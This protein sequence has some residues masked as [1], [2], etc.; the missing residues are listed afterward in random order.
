MLRVISDSGNF[1]VPYDTSPMSI[2]YS[3]EANDW[4]I[5]IDS[6]VMARYASLDNVNEAIQDM[7]QAYLNG[8]K[9]FRFPTNHEKE[10]PNNE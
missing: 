4:T 5:R 3:A 9:F 2:Q 8:Y 7:R 6:F 10:A 1:E